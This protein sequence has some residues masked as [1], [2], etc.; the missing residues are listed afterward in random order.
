MVKKKK[1]VDV[2]KRTFIFKKINLPEKPVKK[3]EKIRILYKPPKL[4]K[5]PVKQPVKHTKYYIIGLV[6]LIF[7][8]EFLYFYPKYK[9]SSYCSKEI[10]PDRVNLRCEGYNCFAV[11]NLSQSGSPIKYYWKDG[12]KINPYELRFGN[13]ENSK[14][15]SASNINYNQ[16][17]G[18]KNNRIKTPLSYKID[19]TIDFFDRTEQGYKIVGYNCKSSWLGQTS[20]L[21]ALGL[22][23]S[24]LAVLILLSIIKIREIRESTQNR[25]QAPFHPR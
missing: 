25:E 17:L 14:Y 22:I 16:L 8:L 18:F 13:L 2:V 21:I 23:V 5:I 24:L 20:V 6:L 15:L 4:K 12:V 7:A 9:D 19:L 10:I 3:P 11:I 1:R